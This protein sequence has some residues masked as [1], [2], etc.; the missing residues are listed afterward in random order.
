MTETAQDNRKCVVQFCLNHPAKDE[1]LCISHTKT[2]RIIP[3]GTKQKIPNTPFT[4]LYD[5]DTAVSSC[6]KILEMKNLQK[7]ITFIIEQNRKEKQ[8]RNC[9]IAKIHRNF[10]LSLIPKSSEMGSK[11]M[12]EHLIEK[13][14]EKNKLYKFYK[15]G[16]QH[17]NWDNGISICTID[18]QNGKTVLGIYFCKNDDNWKYIIL[19]MKKHNQEKSF[20]D[21]CM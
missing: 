7:D 12:T 16:E 5:E 15:L 3:K 2:H 13:L 19:E 10:I 11:T 20:F 1:K 17:R 21:C 14:T 4:I 18:S 8:K 6:D 9:E